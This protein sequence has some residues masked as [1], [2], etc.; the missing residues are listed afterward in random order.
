MAWLVVGYLTLPLMYFSPEA[1]LSMEKVSDSGEGRWTL[2]AAS[3]LVYP[4][5]SVLF[6]HLILTQL[7]EFRTKS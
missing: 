4:V 2:P 5:I 6:E 3:I 1:H 7:G